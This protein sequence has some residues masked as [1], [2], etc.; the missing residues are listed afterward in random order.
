MLEQKGLLFSLSHYH[1]CC[2]AEDVNEIILLNKDRVREV[3]GVKSLFRGLFINRGQILPLLNLRHLFQMGEDEQDIIPV[4]VMELEQNLLFGLTIAAQTEIIEFNE[5]L[6]EP[7]E[8]GPRGINPRFFKGY[9]SAYGKMIF[10]MALD[11]FKS[12]F[13]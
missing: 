1:L 9:I 4:G 10:I 8:R 7:F 11:G 5:L 3:P 12:Y 6:I 13:L 2:P